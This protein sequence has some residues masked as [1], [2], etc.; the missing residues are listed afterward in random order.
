MGIFID[1]EFPTRCLECPMY[2]DMYRCVWIGRDEFDKEGKME[3]CPLIKLDKPSNLT[4][5]KH[6]K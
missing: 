2:I 1:A 3:S 4:L 6:E 5:D